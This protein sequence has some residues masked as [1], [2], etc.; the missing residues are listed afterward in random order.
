MLVESVMRGASPSVQPQ[1]TG[2]TMADFLSGGRFYVFMK[3]IDVEDKFNVNQILSH[4][5]LDPSNVCW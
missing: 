2:S 5:G 1:N 3:D 4:K